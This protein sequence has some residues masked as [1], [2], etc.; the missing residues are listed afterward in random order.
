MSHEGPYLA[1]VGL[2][3]V[4]LLALGARR[5]IL[6]RVAVR[7]VAR[8]KTQVV[9]AVAGL[10]VATSILSG[11]FVIGDSLNYSIRAEV[12]RDLDLIDET[13]VF[14]GD[15][16]SGLF[17]NVSEYDGLAARR[18]EMPSVDGLGPRIAARASVLNPTAELFEPRAWLVGFDPAADPGLFVLGDGTPAD[19]SALGAGQAYLNDALAASVEARAGDDVSVFLGTSPFPTALEVVDVLRPEGKGPWLGDPVVFVPLPQAQALLGEPRRINQIVVSNAGGVEDGVGLTDAAIADLDAV[20]GPG[21]PYTIRDVKRDA[22]EDADRAADTLTQLFVLLG[23]FTVIAGLMLIVSIFTVLAEERKTEMG[24]QR[25]IGMRRDQ[26]TQLFTLEGFLYALASAALGAV[27]GLVVAG[28]ILIAINEIFAA[29]G[30]GIALRWDADSLLVGFALGFLIT[31]ATITFTS[32][33]I[34]RLNIVRA[35]RNIP[36]PVLH[37]A[38]RG[39]LVAGGLVLLAGVALTVVGYREQRAIL[40]SPGV[41]LAILGLAQLAHRAVGTR[42]AFTAAGAFIVA[43]FV[44]PYEWFPQV[45][46]EITLFIAVGVFLVL[47]GVLLVVFNNEILLNAAA[48][49][50]KGRRHMQPIVRTAMAYPMNR[51]FRS[52]LMIAIFAL[53]IFTIVVM[54][55]IQTQVGLSVTTITEDASGGYD[56]FAVSNP[57]A[58]IFDFEDRLSNASFAGDLAAHEALLFAPAEIALESST[59]LRFYEL[60]GIDAGFADRNGFTFF[61]K[62]DRFAT[63]RDVWR[64]VAV[65]ASAVVIDRGVQPV[66]FGP[67]SG[68]FQVAVGDRLQLKNA[69]GVTRSV[70]VIGILDSIVVRGVFLSSDVVRSGF[71]AVAPSFF[72]FQIGPGA[73]ADAIA[74][75]LERLFLPEQMQ[76]IVLAT[77]VRENL[78]STLDFFDLLQGYLALGLLVGIA[79]LGIVTLR[80]VTERRAEMGVLRALGYRRGMIVQ[81][82]FLENSYVALLGIG[83]GVVLG[84]LLSYRIYRD[85]FTASPAFVIPWDDILLVSGVAYLMS[86]VSAVSPAV[87][88]SRVPPAEALRY[89]E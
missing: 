61:R 34:S 72:L 13:V 22:L 63:E 19:G 67:P 17:F 76:T 56:I 53:V 3:V 52:G 65:N 25:A 26:L 6:L 1:A 62:A 57:R 15:E 9:L 73:D 86:L 33:R 23:T 31:I 87:R 12:F 7:N 45:A 84:I 88:A 28:V 77:V 29:E 80:N 20:L 59:D 32:G 78:Q 74:K 83:L 49:L 46:P 39:Q 30:S 35:V 38:T 55:H 44:A 64:E 60:Y 69:T 85:F 75:D 54:A 8:R 16:G 37:R 51:P 66:D 48:R 5:R 82:V 79:G 40:F 70:E 41:G 27:A 68:D 21:H 50:L 43:W 89:V 10:L 81:S 24:I 2:V 4:A 58:P 71:G 18:A 42:R 14:A 36:E 47:G 11:S